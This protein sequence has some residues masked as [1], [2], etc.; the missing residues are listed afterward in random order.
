[1]TTTT[2]GPRAQ[3]TQPGFVAWLAAATVSATGDGVLYFALAWTASG[4]GPGAVTAVLAAGLVPEVLLTLAGGVAADRWGIRRTLLSC[5]LAMA[6]LIVVLLTA[7]LIGMPLLAL[8]LAVAI[9]QGMVGSIQM[10]ASNVM[11]RLFVTDDGLSRAMA[12]SGS[13]LSVARIAGPP[14][15]AVVVVGLGLEGALLVDLTSFLLVAA[16]LFVVRPPYER[17]R[18]PAPETTAW[19]DVVTGLRAVGRVPGIRPLLASLALVAAG[20]LP[21]LALGVPLLARERDWGATTAGVIEACWIAGTLAI[22]LLVARVGTRARPRPPLVGGPVL[23][24]LGVTALALAPS[25]M[26]AYAAATVMGIGTAAYTTHMFPLYVRCSPDDKLARFQSVLILVQL[27][28]MLLGNLLAGGAI[29][30]W[31]VTP[32]L[33]AAGGVCAAAAVPV[34]ASR[35]LSDL[36]P[37]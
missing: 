23:A 22:G 12:V 29:G 28:M 19:S 26:A 30:V 8:L 20:L 11:P 16:V 37:H 24:A 4:L 32:V 34:L 2:T 21:L 15:G 33:L 14:L 6:A 7:D 35:S 5:T 17:R 9:G 36:T 10:P 31:G 27:A 3:L 1:V 18:A 25:P 13:V